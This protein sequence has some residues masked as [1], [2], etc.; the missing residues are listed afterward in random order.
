MAPPARTPDETVRALEL[1]LER[2]RAY[3]TT[4]DD[5]RVRMPN[6]EAASHRFRGPLPDD[7]DGTLAVIA[8]LFD[9]GLDAHVRSS[10][11][12]FFHWVIGGATPAA[13]AADW[14]T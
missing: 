13:R 3:V 6:A 5:D 10:G 4:L 7:G 12:R 2:A 11:P 8:R 1:V 14:I 9:E